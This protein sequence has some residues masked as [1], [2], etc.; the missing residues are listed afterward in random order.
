VSLVFYPVKGLHDGGK[1]LAMAERFVPLQKGLYDGGKDY[2][3]AERFSPW[4]KGF[5]H[6]GEVHATAKVCTMKE[7]FVRLRKI[8]TMAERFG[9]RFS[10]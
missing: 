2:A 9:K 5:R 10:P 1:V 3:M 4:Q 8:L 7:M 6:G